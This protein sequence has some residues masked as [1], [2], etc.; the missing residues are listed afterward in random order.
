M[1]TGVVEAEAEDEAEGPLLTTRLDRTHA[2]QTTVVGDAAD[3]AD[4]IGLKVL[5]GPTCDPKLEEESCLRP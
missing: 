4:L 5:T 1:E 3:E 2:A